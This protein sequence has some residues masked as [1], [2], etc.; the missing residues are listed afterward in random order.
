MITHTLAK[1]A[2]SVVGL[3]WDGA[4]LWAGDWETCTLFRLAADGAIQAQFAAPG[5]MVGM[6]FV[7]GTLLAVISDQESDDRS[8]HRFNPSDGSWETGAT[9]CPDDTGSQLSWDG[10]RLWLSQR[11]NKRIVRLTPAGSVEHEIEM[12][13]EVTGIHWSGPA[14]W[15]N[16]RFE[17]GVSDITR[18][19]REGAPG[20]RLERYLSGFVSLAFDG[21]GFW[22]SDLRGTT[23]VKASPP[24]LA[25]TR[26][27]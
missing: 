13:A 6:T 10:D 3:A 8:I 19:V 7:D 9:R 15:A 14:L 21:S 11:H 22:M 1:P 2:P 16:L 12:P 17:K 25:P 26:T 27:S 18:F 23:I 20:E 24:G 5:R 4:S